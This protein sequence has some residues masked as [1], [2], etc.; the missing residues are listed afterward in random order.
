[1][2]TGPNNQS[3]KARLIRFLIYILIGFGAAWVYRQMK[4]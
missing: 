4:K 1:M 3:T 2:S